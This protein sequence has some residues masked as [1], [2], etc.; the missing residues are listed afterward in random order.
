M[1]HPSLAEAQTTLAKGAAL[2]V[3][4]GFM[5]RLEALTT[6]AAIAGAAAA[7][8]VSAAGRSRRGALPEFETAAALV[9]SAPPLQVIN[10]YVYTYMY[11]R[12]NP[13]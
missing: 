13:R 5:L 10:I 6:S 12:V 1:Q 8:I 2:G 4:D 11:V 7:A 9:A 3:S